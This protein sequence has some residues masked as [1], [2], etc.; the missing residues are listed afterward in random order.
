MGAEKLQRPITVATGFDQER[1]TWHG[2]RRH[3][4]QRAKRPGFRAKPRFIATV[5]IL[6][7]DIGDRGLSDG[8]FVDDYP[9]CNRERE[10]TRQTRPHAAASTISRTA[11]S[12][13]GCRR[14]YLVQGRIHC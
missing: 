10:R 9:N 11:P 5:G 6:D 14:Q 3:V 1:V 4:A 2:D 8:R 13:V 7:V 12:R